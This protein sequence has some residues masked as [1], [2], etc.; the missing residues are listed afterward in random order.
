M[1]RHSS[2]GQDKPSS[3]KEKATPS[4][5]IS[6]TSV[7]TSGELSR[8]RIGTASTIKAPPA[9]R[10]PQLTSVA[11]VSPSV[12]APP[13]PASAFLGPS[14]DQ[15]SRAAD[16]RSDQE[17]K[18]AEAECQK[19]RQAEAEELREHQ[20]NERRRAERRQK[21]A[22]YYEQKE[23]REQELRNADKKR[24]R[25]RRREKE[26]QREEKEMQRQCEQLQADPPQLEE[27]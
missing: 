18:L 7:T 16:L 14:D 17:R 6:T 22:G 8:S 24:E 5:A 1:R 25:E 10:K 23:R 27:D 3:G 19:R 11:T 20:E 2:S 21:E 12:R 9:P 13:S 26:K 15:L 4:P